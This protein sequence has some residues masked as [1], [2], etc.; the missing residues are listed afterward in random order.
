MA[1]PRLAQAHTRALA[2][3]GKGVVWVDG[4]HHS[5]EYSGVYFALAWAQYLVEDYGADPTATW[6]VENRHTW[7]MPM[8]NPDGSHAFGRLNAHGVNINRNYP[9]IWDGEGHDPKSVS[10][11]DAMTSDVVTVKS[12]LSVREAAQI[13]FD[14]WFRHLPVTTSDGTVVGRGTHDELLDTCGTYREIVESQL[15]AEE[16]A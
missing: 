4:G 9:V 2:K 7:I 3:E 1:V 13:M 15:T 8:V 6:I 5:N 16:A 12:D 10:L 11:K 14:K